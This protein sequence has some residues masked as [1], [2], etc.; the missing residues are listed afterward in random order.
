MK[1][2]QS[3]ITIKPAPPFDFDAAAYSHGWVVLSPNSWDEDGRVLRRVE[4]LKSGKVAMLA[5][6][7]NGAVR[8]PEIRVA[9]QSA[10]RLNGR[11]RTE[12]EDGVRHMFRV[13]E[14]IRAFYR[15][16]R[17]RGGQWL[18]V[19][20]GKGRLL[21]SPGLFEDI[22]KVICTTNIQWGGTRKMVE[23]IVN[24]YGATY[25][26]EPS[27][28]AFPVPEAI[29]SE[30]PGE[31]AAKVRM[32]YRAP[33]VH[34]LAGQLAA[35][36]L[37]LESLRDPELPTADLKKRLLAIKGVGP[38]AAATL[39]MLLGRYD[40]LAVDTVARG[41]V[42]NKYFDGGKA[43]DAQIREVYEGWAEWKFLAYW[44]D[45][46]QGFQEKL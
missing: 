10:G 13:D 9:V 17:K 39:L 37:D 44:F 4:R 45:L 1:K 19:T 7:G 35:G 28:R 40:D 15:L 22:V 12:I 16:A 25:P 2:V 33:Y 31:F 20:T 26:A 36:K 32:G 29:A 21:R 24:S 3:Q 46:W 6:S 38:Y 41:F 18:E 5:I 42:S 23:N 43:T 27:L 30:D 11:E 14:D 34:E 8:K